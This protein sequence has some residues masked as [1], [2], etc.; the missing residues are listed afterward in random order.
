MLKICI[1]IDSMFFVGFLIGF[2]FKFCGNKDEK[3][4][5]KLIYYQDDGKVVIDSY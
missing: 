2:N 5:G 3:V 1:D 4:N